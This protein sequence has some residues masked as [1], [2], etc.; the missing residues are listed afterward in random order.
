MTNIHR[1]A[2][3]SLAALLLAACGMF[4]PAPT[5]PEA[6]GQAEVAAQNTGLPPL[7]PTRL[8]PVKSWATFYQIPP[9]QA[10]VDQLAKLDVQ[11]IQPRAFTPDQIRTLQVLGN[12]V[13]YLA[14]GEVGPNN[15]YFVNGQQVLG[16]TIIAQNPGWFVGKN[17]SF[18]APLVNLANPAA[19]RFIVEQGRYLLG[20]E[21]DGLFLDTVD[22]AELFTTFP[23]SNNVDQPKSPS[24]RFENRFVILDAGRPDYETMRRAYVQT[25]RELRALS[26]THSLIQNGGFDVLLDADNGGEGS[27]RHIDAVMHES[28]TTHYSLKFPGPSQSLDPRNY[29]SWRDDFRRTPADEAERRQIAADKAFRDNRDAKARAFRMR[30][31][32]VLAQEFAAGDPATFTGNP[33]NNNLICWGFARARAEGWV[34]SYADAFFNFRFEYPETAAAIRANEGCA[35][36][37]FTVHPDALLEFTPRVVY[38]VPGRTVQTAVRVVSV[39]GYSASVALSFGPL[40]SGVTASFSQAS[41][42]PGSS[43]TLNVSVSAGTP[44]RTYILPVRRM[45]GGFTMT[46][47]LRLVVRQPNGQSVWVT[48]AGN[49]TIAAFENAAGLTPASTPSGSA[50]G[51]AQPYD[52]EVD[53]QGVQYVV[54]NVGNPAAA[55]PAGRVLRYASLNLSIPVQV[56]TNGLNYP[57]SAALDAGNNLWVANSALDFTGTSRGTPSIRYFAPNATSPTGGFD[58]P[59]GYGSPLQ[60]D[61]GP[62]GRLWASTSFGLLVGFRTVATAPTIDAVISLP[63][64]L[65][66]I[67]SLTFDNGGNLWLSGLNGAQGRLV[68]LPGSALAATGVTFAVDRSASVNATLSS[69]LFDPFGV[70]VDSAGNLWAVNQTDASGTGP[71]S[72]VRYAAADLTTP[73]ATPSLTLPQATRFILGIA[74]GL[75]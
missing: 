35:D 45:V 6:E 26:S 10:T 28:A 42:A 65:S 40:P 61:F 29:T 20:L 14:I 33:Q 32:L 19:R 41:A 60:I 25:I 73:A 13:V 1:T 50:G 70:A 38:A 72:L 69:G 21:Y 56:I 64:A 36:Y 54:E 43:V 15:L 71:G 57:T 48:N 17:K 4:S 44:A 18:D 2:L 55:Q 12:A 31:G 27:E 30:G 49:S 51:I 39:K 53:S 75:P 74:V 23:D 7:R 5:A 9:N 47:D 62:D 68:R 67:K 66:N 16:S 24:L 22:D 52:I 8:G 11:I 58:F 63:A 59:A 37:N 34:P 46:Y 3:G